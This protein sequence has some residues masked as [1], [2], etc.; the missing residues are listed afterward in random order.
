ME[1]LGAWAQVSVLG[2]IP[3]IM[4]RKDRRRKLIKRILIAAIILTTLAAAPI[5]FHFFIMDLDIFWAKLM[6]LMA[7]Y[8]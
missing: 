8:M 5:I 1:E 6:R 2:S 7:K 4:T 3:H